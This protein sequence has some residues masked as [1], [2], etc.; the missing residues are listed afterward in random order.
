MRA[1]KGFLLSFVFLIFCLYMIFSIQEIFNGFSEIKNEAFIG[2]VSD[3]IDSPN[4][5]PAFETNDDSANQLQI[6]ALDISAQSAISVWT[7]FAQPEKV[8]FSKNNQRKLPVASITK[9]MTALVVVENFDLSKKIQISADAVN[10]TDEPEKEILKAGEIFYAGDLLNAMLIGSDNA[11]S[12][13]LA[14]S[15]GVDKFVSLMNN[16]AKEL[17]LLDTSFSDSSGLGVVNFSTA[18]DMAKLAGH[19]LKDKKAVFMITTMPDFDLY[20]ADGK[21]LHK[22]SNTN[23]LLND[24]KLSKRIIG[25]KTG[26]TRTA[27]ECLLLIT[28]ALNN[29]G[30]LINVIL[31]S[32]SRF[33]EMPEIINWVDTNYQW[34]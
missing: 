28:K 31:N 6:G 5:K 11:A 17:G 27:G 8:L 16:K 3:S 22:I 9:L 30:Y 32:E 4:S 13:A 10:Q 24:P 25:S 20:T 1:I 21:I 34:Q 33:Q 14:E 7:D 26:T 15:I 19:L 12:Y 23:K 2:S 18:Q 29:K